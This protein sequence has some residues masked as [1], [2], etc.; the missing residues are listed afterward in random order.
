METTTGDKYNELDNDEL[1]IAVA[2]SKGWKVV[3]IKNHDVFFLNSPLPSDGSVCR[4]GN[5]YQLEDAAWGELD[6]LKCPQYSTDESSVFG[7]L[8]DLESEYVSFS[9]SS[10]VPNSDDPVYEVMIES[11]IGNFYATDITLPRAICQA[12]LVYVEAKEKSKE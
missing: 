1:R 8:Y 6:Y 9:I 2:K 11:R 12:Y 5:C 3:H 4:C 7:L 10:I